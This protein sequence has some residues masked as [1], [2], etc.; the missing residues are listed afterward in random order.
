MPSAVQAILNGV[1]LSQEAASPDYTV[2]AAVV[3]LGFTM[4]ADDDLQFHYPY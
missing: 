4:N 1:V 2:N 3:T